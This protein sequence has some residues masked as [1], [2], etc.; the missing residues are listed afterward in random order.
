[1]CV[2]T[3]TLLPQLIGVQFREKGEQDMDINFVL[4]NDGQQLRRSSCI[5]YQSWGGPP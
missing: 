5:T 1:M 3:Y 4:E 2:S